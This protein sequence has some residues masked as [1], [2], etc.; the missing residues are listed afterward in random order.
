MSNTLDYI[1]GNVE[2]NQVY[3]VIRLPTTTKAH[4]TT[5]AQRQ[6][7][8]LTTTLPPMSTVYEDEYFPEI[9]T[10]LVNSQQILNNIKYYNF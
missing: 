9:V 5:K 7:I 8:P 1:L 10:N 3:E 4:T 2:K 6:S